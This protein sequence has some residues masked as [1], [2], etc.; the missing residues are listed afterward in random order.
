VSA[1]E[2]RSLVGVMSMDN[3]ASKGLVTT[4]SDFAPGCKDEFAKMMPSRLELVNGPSLRQ[5]LSKIVSLNLKSA[6]REK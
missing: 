1:D 2:V 6:D 4:T 5:R 3:L